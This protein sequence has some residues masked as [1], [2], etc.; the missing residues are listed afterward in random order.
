MESYENSSAR[1]RGALWM[2]RAA[3]ERCGKKLQ[4][5]HAHKTNAGHLI[6]FDLWEFDGDYYD[7]TTY[8]IDDQGQPNANAQVIRGGRYY[9]VMLA[10]LESLLREAGFRD[11]TTLRD[12]FYQPLLVGTKKV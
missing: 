4:P 10:R 12:R 2:R 8:L 6:V 3:L 7:F 5:R 9:C 11:V 1:P